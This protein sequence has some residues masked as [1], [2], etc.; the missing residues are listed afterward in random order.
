[1]TE[2]RANGNRKIATHIDIEDAKRLPKKL[3]KEIDAFTMPDAGRHLSI[4]D[5]PTAKYR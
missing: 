3:A 4:R 5:A 1:L 2:R